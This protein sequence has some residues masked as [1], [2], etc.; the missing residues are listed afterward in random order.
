MSSP[1]RWRMP[2]FKIKW[3]DG[4]REPQC[5]PKGASIKASR[6]MH[7]VI[8]SGRL[9]KPSRIVKDGEGRIVSTAAA[10]V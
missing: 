7:G 9:L 6:D 1:D 10:A 5:P 4:K 3:H 2:K 8:Y